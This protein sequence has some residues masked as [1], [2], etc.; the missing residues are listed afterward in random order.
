MV[1]RQR[2]GH[3]D[4][5]LASLLCNCQTPERMIAL[6][7]HGARQTRQ[8]AQLFRRRMA[9]K[10]LRRRAEH[11]VVARQLAGN[12]VRRDIAEANIEIHPFID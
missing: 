5:V 2:P 3:F 9:G 6:F 11:A 7:N 8:I 12:R 10:E 4:G 1:G